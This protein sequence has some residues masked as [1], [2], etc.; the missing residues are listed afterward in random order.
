MEENEIY[1]SIELLVA[2]FL[3]GILFSLLIIPDLVN[4]GLF[5][6]KDFSF[7]LEEYTIIGIIMGPL[8]RGCDT[9][10]YKYILNYN[11]LNHCL[12]IKYRNFRKAWSN[13]L[14]DK[15]YIL[16][17]KLNKENRNLVSYVESLADGYLW[18]SFIFFIKSLFLLINLNIYLGLLALSLS[19]VIFYEGMDYLEEYIELLKYNK[20]EPLILPVLH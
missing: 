7:S 16:V 17:S 4:I 13:I 3:P 14:T 19:W 2:Y 1:K 5:Y 20:V 12:W 8:L 9:L 10:L 18:T 6:K 11:I 15:K